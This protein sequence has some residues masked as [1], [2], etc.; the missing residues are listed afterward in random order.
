MLVF[1]H[2]MLQTTKQKHSKFVYKFS[3][4]VIDGQGFVLATYKDCSE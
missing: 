2:R 1:Q 3:S 4:L